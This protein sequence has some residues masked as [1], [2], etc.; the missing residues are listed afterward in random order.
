MPS[1]YRRE[2]LAAFPDIAKGH[3]ELARRFFEYYGAVFQPGALGIRVKALAA[4]GAAHIVQCPYCIDA[5]TKSALE[6]GADLE[7]L[8]ETVHVAAAVRAGAT[9]VLGMQAMTQAEALT[10][11]E[12]PAPEAEG[13]YDP[14]HLALREKH[15]KL[16]TTL[17]EPQKSW[18]TRAFSDGSLEARDKAAI[19]LAAA[20]ALSCPY[21]IDAAGRRCRSARLDLAAMTEAVHVAAAIR[22]GASL[23]HGIQMLERAG[24]SGAET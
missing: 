10:M 24:P 4:L 16:P 1:Y 3:P 19:A 22:G 6:A 13:Y 11:G 2:H 8:S 15:E 17:F 21:A 20:H 12:P 23:I 9:L 18:E 7:Q 14:A 5:Y